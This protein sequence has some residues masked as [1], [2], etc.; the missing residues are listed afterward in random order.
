MCQF[1]LE[2][3]TQ[4]THKRLGWGCGVRG[5]GGQQ[6]DRDRRRERGHAETA[7][8]WGRRAAE[9]ETERMN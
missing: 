1:L 4:R 5:G 3:L 7:V 6:R 9:T 2:H 8:R